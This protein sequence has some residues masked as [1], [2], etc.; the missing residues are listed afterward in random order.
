ME[1]YEIDEI[2]SFGVSVIVKISFVEGI[3]ERL[4]YRKIK[5]E[6]LEK[7]FQFVL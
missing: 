4:K 2:I 1:G 3:G 6:K 7:Y 5:G